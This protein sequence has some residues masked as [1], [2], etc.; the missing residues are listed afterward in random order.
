[1]R[2]RD[3]GAKPFRNDYSHHA[4]NPASINMSG[5]GGRHRL[6]EDVYRKQHYEL[7]NDNYDQSYAGT[8][9]RT[10]GPHL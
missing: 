10:L 9:G 1:M 8:K 6:G 7:G 3:L 5:L 2:Q 4:T